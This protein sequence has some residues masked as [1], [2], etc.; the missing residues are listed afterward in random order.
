MTLANEFKAG[1]ADRETARKGFSLWMSPTRG[2]VCVEAWA[3]KQD[4]SQR[5]QFPDGSILIIHSDGSETA[6]VLEE[7]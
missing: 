6:D 2:M 5:L 7:L 1:P 4:G 3:M